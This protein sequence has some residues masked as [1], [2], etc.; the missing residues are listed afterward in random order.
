MNCSYVTMTGK[1]A[2]NKGQHLNVQDSRYLRRLRVTSLGTILPL[3]EAG[4]T[5]RS[6]LATGAIFTPCTNLQRIKVL[7][8]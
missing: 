8:Q 4:Y 5:S 6:L 3:G 1:C 2:A 7:Q